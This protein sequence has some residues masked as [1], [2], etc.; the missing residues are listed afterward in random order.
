MWLTVSYSSPHNLHLLFCCILAIFALIYFVLIEIFCSVSFWDIIIIMI[1]INTQRFLVYIFANKTFISSYLFSVFLLL[2]EVFFFVIF[3]FRF[4]HR[5]SSFPLGLLEVKSFFFMN[6]WRCWH[7]LYVPCD[8]TVWTF[9]SRRYQ[10][11]YLQLL[12]HTFNRPFCC[13][14]YE[15][16]LL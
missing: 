3:L 15:K 11:F 7:C 13:N 6:V 12:G 9:S 2:A 4:L 8:Q 5:F 10:W 16:L 14:S 1:C